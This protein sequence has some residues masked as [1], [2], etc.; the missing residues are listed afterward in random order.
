M[1]FSLDE[2]D[3]PPDCRDVLNTAAVLETTEFNVFCLAHRHWFGGVLPDG[4]MERF[5]VPYMLEDIVPPWVRSF[6]RVVLDAYQRGEL[7]IRQYVK[8]E[9]PVSTT[10]FRQIK[11][12][13]VTA[14]IAVIVLLVLAQEAARQVGLSTQC[15]FPPCH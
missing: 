7:D 14:A 1:F 2:D 12:H 5:Y 6:C 8:P 3:L 13:L 9:T 11:K 15:M 4:A 10:T